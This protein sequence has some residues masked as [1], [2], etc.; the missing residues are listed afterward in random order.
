MNPGLIQIKLINEQGPIEI[1]STWNKPKIALLIPDAI[2][3]QMNGYLSFKLTPKIAG[4][5]I[6]A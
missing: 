1:E 4:S 5:V 6:P 2:A 3:P